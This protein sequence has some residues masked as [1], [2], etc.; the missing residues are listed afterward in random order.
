MKDKKFHTFIMDISTYLEIVELA[1]KHGKKPGDEM[2]EELIEVMKK[3]G[4]IQYLGKTDKDLD[5]LA[6]ELRERGIRVF[7]PKEEQRRKM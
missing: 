2:N 3:K 7:N 4:K 6:G 5:L 1:K